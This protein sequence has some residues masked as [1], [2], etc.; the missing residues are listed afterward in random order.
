MRLRDIIPFQSYN[1][2]DNWGKAHR[3][4][5]PKLIYE[6]K[7]GKIPDQWADGIFDEFICNYSDHSVASIR[8][9]GFPIE[10]QKRIREQWA[11]SGLKDLLKTIAEHPQTYMW[12]AYDRVDKI[13]RGYTNKHYEAATVRMIV[14]LQPCLFSTIVTAK[15]IDNVVHYL[16][17]HQI[18]GFD[19][20]NYGGDILHKN[21]ML[22]QFLIS[23]YPEQN[24]LDL[25]TVAWR[26]PDQFDRIETKMKEL[27]QYKQL[28]L[29]KKQIILQGAPGTGKTYSTAQLALAVIGVNDIDYSNHK[30]VM[31]RYKALQENGQIEF[32]TFHQS[33][34]YEDFVEGIKPELTESGV[35]YS[36]VDG[37]FK[38]I[39]AAAACHVIS[40]FDTVY[41]SFIK[42]IED[43]DESEPLILKTKKGKE[44]G[45][46]PN[47][48]GN[49]SLLTG[50][51]K[52]KN[53]VIQRDSIEK[54]LNGDKQVDW[55]YYII[56]VIDYLKT[57]YN[58]NIKEEQTTKNY[59]LIID[60][61]NRGNVSKIFGEL[62]TLI[63]ADKRDDGAHRLTVRLPYSNAEFSI[64]G[65]L[66]IIGTMNTTDR[67]VGSLDYA[68]RRRF[69]FV[70][71]KANRH[72][73]EDYYKSIDN[74]TLCQLA[75]DRYSR[76]ESFLLS[77]ASDLDIEDL[78]IGHSFFMASNEDA[79][80]MKWNYEVLPLLKEYY[81]DGIINKRW[82]EKL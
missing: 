5:V 43:Y 8:Q 76:V 14:S 73:I 28:L 49:L 64:P 33:L 72:I 12:E 46:C 13:I 30:S 69:A 1:V 78:M 56:G 55:Y 20:D 40:N 37:V 23:E 11:T 79:L 80:N 52:Q 35:T 77:C 2:H 63:E 48:K 17:T 25:A 21:R 16:Q 70:T 61:I 59:V 68:L 65:N 38:R 54:V 45:V 31:E 50:I 75:C 26:I 32:V 44:F 4:F 39:C 57:K 9:G 51:N 62:I 27:N 36:V 82:T 67:S 6:V 34:D 47:S 53:G 71:V 19:Y 41:E 66:F 29:H 42:D 24:P 74:L 18:D 7:A 10:S 81:K 15:N 58:L 3:A 22:Q 60:E